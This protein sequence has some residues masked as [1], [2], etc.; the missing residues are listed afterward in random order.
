VRDGES[1]VVGERGPEVLTMNGGGGRI[2]PNEKLRNGGGKTVNQQANITF[3]VNTV[4]ADGF[5]E[6][7]N[8]RRGQI[9][10][11]VNAALYDQ[12]KGAFA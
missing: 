4:D 9:V 2:I 8:S 1:Y 12:G 11:M 6:L 10:N 7:L 5:D 3:Q